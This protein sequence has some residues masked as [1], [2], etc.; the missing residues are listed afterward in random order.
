MI[1]KQFDMFS[2]YYLI[3]YVLFSLLYIVFLKQKLQKEQY[4][5]TYQRFLNISNTTK[6]DAQLSYA[7]FSITSLQLELLFT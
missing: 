2:F 5:P 1:T 7:S 6:K 3:G 4:A